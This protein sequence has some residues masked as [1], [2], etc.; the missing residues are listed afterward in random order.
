MTFKRI[1]QDF[2]Y[3]HDV[4][5]VW[6]FWS[7]NTLWFCFHISVSAARKRLFWLSVES[8][9]FSGKTCSLASLVLGFEF[10]LGL[11]LRKQTAWVLVRLCGFLMA[12]IEY[13]IS[14]K[15]R[16]Q[17]VSKFEFIHLNC[18]TVKLINYI[19]QCVYF[20]F[21]I[22]TSKSSTVSH[23]LAPRRQRTFLSQREE[24]VLCFHQ[25]TIQCLTI[26]YLYLFRMSVLKVDGINGP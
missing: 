21:S 22:S 24:M 17:H 12:L 16:K 19:L 7:H 25:Y 11:S 2:A 6:P 18:L 13:F 8:I 1:L 20:Y 5:F 10:L 4:A 15:P 3:W 26:Q 14:H 23:W 9:V